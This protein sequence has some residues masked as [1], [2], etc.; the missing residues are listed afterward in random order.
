LSVQQFINKVPYVQVTQHTL[1]LLPTSLRG[2]NI[3]FVGSDPL[4]ILQ[5][6]CPLNSKSFLHTNLLYLV[7][8]IAQY[9]KLTNKNSRLHLA[10]FLQGMDL[11]QS[12]RSTPTPKKN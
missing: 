10:T 6:S 11:R 12:A 5:L 2:T 3:L 8:E 1:N 4:L 9:L 7:V